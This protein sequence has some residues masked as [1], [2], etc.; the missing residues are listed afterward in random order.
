MEFPESKIKMIVKEGTEKA[1]SLCKWKTPA[2]QDPTQGLCTVMRT[3]EGGIWQRLV[4]NIYN[5][6][7]PNFEKGTLSFR[8]H[9]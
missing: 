3:E 8:D 2:H 4:L 7:C 1:C 6:T 5:T 9:A